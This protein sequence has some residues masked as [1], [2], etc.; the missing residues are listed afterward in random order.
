MGEVEGSEPL[1]CE[2][3]R[4]RESLIQ[5]LFH[6]VR[7]EQED[8][9]AF[10]EEAARLLGINLTDLR[11]RG[12]WTGEAPC[13]SASWRKRRG[14]PAVLPQRWWIAWRRLDMPPEPGTRRTV[15]GSW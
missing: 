8:V 6:Q 5:E 13:P 1:T 7:A 2:P 15:A 4:V 11:V 9:Q 12:S 14:S 3:R 10:D